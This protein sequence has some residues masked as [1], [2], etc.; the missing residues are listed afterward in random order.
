[1]HKGGNIERS[2]DDEADM[3]M[4]STSTDGDSDAQSDDPLRRQVE[5][6]TRLVPCVN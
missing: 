4:Q 6:V 2:E 3:D 1:M 5:E